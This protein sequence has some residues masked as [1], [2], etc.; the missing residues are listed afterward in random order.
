[1]KT[2]GN[3]PSRAMTPN[4]SKQSS[5]TLCRKWDLEKERLDQWSFS[6]LIK[7][8][9]DSAAKWFTDLENRIDLCGRLGDNISFH[10]G[11]YST[12]GFNVLLT[13]DPHDRTHMEEIQ[14]V[15]N[16]EINAILAARWAKL[17]E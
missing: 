8:D 7:V 17:V 6:T 3:P 9:S 15:N 13:L 16:L 11:T 5:T 2:S 14:E 10:T 12:I 1:M 4:M